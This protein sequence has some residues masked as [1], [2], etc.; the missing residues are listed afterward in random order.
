[1]RVWK[2]CVC[3]SLLL[4]LTWLLTSPNVVA[5]DNTQRNKQPAGKK[6]ARVKAFMRK[7]LVAADQIL[8]GLTNPDMKLVRKGATFMIHMNKEAMW[9]SF[10]S[11]SYIQDSAD[12]VRTAE[13]LVKLAEASDLEGASHTYAQLTIQCVSCH[14][15]VRNQDQRIAHSS[16]RTNSFTAAE[17]GMV[18]SAKSRFPLSTLSIRSQTE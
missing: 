18:V 17:K 6:N 14:R 13:R 8:E 3:V 5:Q 9:A 11:P 12:F 15:R 7:K 2:I 10:R 1:M 16:T 4:G